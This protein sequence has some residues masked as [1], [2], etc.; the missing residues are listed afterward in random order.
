MNRAFEDSDL[1][2]QS[3]DL[4]LRSRRDEKCE[5]GSGH[6]RREFGESGIFRTRLR[7]FQNFET[8]NQI[9]VGNQ[10]PRQAQG[11]SVQFSVFNLGTRANS[12]VLF[13]TS[14]TPRLR[15]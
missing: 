12:R 7:S 13:V 9:I 15:A 5:Q 14:V 6:R 4:E 2:A 10:L 1:M 11:V 3:Q 8:H